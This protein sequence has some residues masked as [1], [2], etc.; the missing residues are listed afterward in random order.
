MDLELLPFGLVGLFRR[1]SRTIRR[2]D[3]GMV[4][5]TWSIAHKPCSLLYMKRDSGN[6]G[7]IDQSA[8]GI[9]IHQGPWD[10]DA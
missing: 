2:V 7:G 3:V 4:T 1:S 9:G 10:D 8:S 6:E 5:V